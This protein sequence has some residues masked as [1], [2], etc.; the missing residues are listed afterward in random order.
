M[1]EVCQVK[2]RPNRFCSQ[3]LVFAVAISIGVVTGCATTTQ[4]G[5]DTPPVVS[6]S[7]PPVAT[8]ATSV[9]DGV[10]TSSQAS[11]GEQTFDA[12]CSFCHAPNEFS[13][14]RFMLMWN[15]QTA[16]DIFDL[17]STQMPEGNPGS[18]RPAEYASVVAYILSLNGYPPGE[19]PLPAD[20]S[21]LQNLQ[22][23]ARP[24]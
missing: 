9:L 17:V 11:F 5:S 24:R 2:S 22:I 20:L 21:A 4:G 18:L 13:G 10:F 7:P 23:E 6:P 12:E 15:G 19:D 3:L 16:G 1:S 14:G 8:A